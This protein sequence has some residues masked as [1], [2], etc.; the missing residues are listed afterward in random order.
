MTPA[1]DT[2]AEVEV[3]RPV[4]TGRWTYDVADPPYGWPTAEWPTDV[5]DPAQLAEY[6]SNVDPLVALPTAR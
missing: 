5:P 6:Q 2:A 1:D 3:S 4:T